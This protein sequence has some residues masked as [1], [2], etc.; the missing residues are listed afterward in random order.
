[1][2]CCVVCL[3]AGSSI[4]LSSDSNDK[5]ESSAT[6][7]TDVTSGCGDERLPWVSLTNVQ[8]GTR[9]HVMMESTF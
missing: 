8:I 7:E 5:I 3:T 9:R 6:Q 4:P 1:M 2:P